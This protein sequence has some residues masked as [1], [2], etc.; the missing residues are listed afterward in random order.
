M[1][2]LQLGQAIKF[3]NFHDSALTRFIMRKCANNQNIGFYFF[4]LLKSEIH[5]PEVGHRL[6]CVSSDVFE[7]F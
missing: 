7:F 2:M 1:V 3:E 6:G 4:W 5:T